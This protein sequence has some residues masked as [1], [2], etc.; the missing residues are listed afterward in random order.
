[1]TE[2]TVPDLRL[3]TDPSK[4]TIVFV[5]LYIYNQLFHTQ[6]TFQTPFQEYVN[7]RNLNRVSF[8]PKSRL[9]Y[10]LSLENVVCV[11]PNHCASHPPLSISSTQ[12]NYRNTCLSMLP[13]TTPQHTVTR[14]QNVQFQPNRKPPISSTPKLSSP[15]SNSPTTQSS[16]FH[17]P[18]SIPRSKISIVHI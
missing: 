16:Y 14:I 13:L 4:Q 5:H 18:I 11:V 7:L 17:Y 15:T 2:D 12:H 6:Q 1:M 8:F 9:Q 10:P 3:N